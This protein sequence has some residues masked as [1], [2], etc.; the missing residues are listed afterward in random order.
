MLFPVI[1]VKDN[2]NGTEHILGTNSH[3]SLYI[4]AETGGP[5]SGHGGLK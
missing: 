4:D 1:K 2:Y 5:A 3:D